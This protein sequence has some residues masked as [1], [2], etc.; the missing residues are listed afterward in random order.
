MSF[1]GD[2]KSFPVPSLNTGDN[3][4]LS[5]AADK[6]TD[7]AEHA[8]HADRRSHRRRVASIAVSTG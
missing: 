4:F 1:L 7:G 2:T 5:Y 8:T 6:Q 3:S